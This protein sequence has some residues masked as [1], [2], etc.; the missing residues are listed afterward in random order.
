[1][2]RN[3]A[4]IF[5]GLAL[6]MAV[7]VTA[8]SASAKPFSTHA[9]TPK[10]ELEV[11]ESGR[12]HGVSKRRRLQHKGIKQGGVSHS[13]GTKP[14]GFPYGRVER[15]GFHQGHHKPL[16]FPYGRLQ[17]SG[18]NATSRHGG[19]QVNIGGHQSQKKVGRR[20]GH[21]RHPLTHGLRRKRYLRHS[22][23]HVN[24]SRYR[25]YPTQ[26]IYQ[27]YPVVE[28]I[29]V[30]SPQVVPQPLTGEIPGTVQNRKPKRPVK[31]VHVNTGS[32][33][34]S[35]LLNGGIQEASSEDV[36]GIDLQLVEG[37]TN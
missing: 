23:H 37:P 4:I 25:H 6:G 24:S 1:M 30:V 14:L 26:V 21:K 10:S 13:V 5:A 12:R 35:A 28:K 7:S 36:L 20:F 8:E 27:E 17:P 11:H 9:G 3:V 2:N 18:V 32:L 22:G 29:V 16:G 34:P 33:D 15:R 19:I 31:F